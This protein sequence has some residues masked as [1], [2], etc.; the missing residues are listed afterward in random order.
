MAARVGAMEVGQLPVKVSQVEAC[1]VK[2]GL[3]CPTPPLALRHPPSAVSVSEVG[4][5]ARP[6]LGVTYAETKAVFGRG[7]GG[8]AVVCPNA[9]PA[10]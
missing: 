10:A 3:A 1:E 6:V 2:A 5:E 8:P 9:R 7:A 4:T